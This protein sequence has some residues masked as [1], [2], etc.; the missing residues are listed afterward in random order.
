MSV[1]VRNRAPVFYS[2]RK[3]F[4]FIALRLNVVRASRPPLFP[5]SPLVKLSMAMNANASAADERRGVSASV[6]PQNHAV[7]EAPRDMAGKLLDVLNSDGPVIDSG[8]KK[9]AELAA[10]R[11]RV[12]SE[13]KR[14][15]QQLRNEERKRKRIMQK[16][17]YLSNTD[18]V[19]VL[20]IRQSKAAT[21]ATAKA[22][23]AEAAS[24]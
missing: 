3:S 10:E 15:T 19:E 17:Q 9:V 12:Q 8:K 11:K 5:Q 6:E 4:S 24:S 20:T 2:L 21:A 16:S 22:K 13:K 14:L 7:V 23:A 18:L 1:N